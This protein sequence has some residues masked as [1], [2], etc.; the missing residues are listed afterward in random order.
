MNECEHISMGTCKILSKEKSDSFNSGS[1]IVQGGI[2]CGKNLHVKH[3]ILCD[4]IGL[5]ENI[6]S[7]KNENFIK[8]YNNIIP[9]DS[10]ISI[11][12]SNK[13]WNSIFSRNL[14]F[15]NSLVGN[16]VNIQNL[17]VD[18]NC[19]L[20]SNSVLLKKGIHECLVNI[21]SR[22][23][24]V[25][26]KSPEVSFQ[27]YENKENILNINSNNIEINSILNIKNND[28]IIMTFN[29]IERRAL[30]N[31][32]LFVA[33]SII[34]SFK[35]ITLKNSCQLDLDS[36]INLFKLESNDNIKI[37]LSTDDVTIGVTRKIIIYN[38]INEIYVNIENMVDLKDKYSGA[39]FLFD[40]KRWILI[41]KF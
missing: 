8:F 26:F 12:N 9:D 10:S 14:V 2:G 24:Q 21:D 30:I 19:L 18:N 38:N 22:N 27:N 13:S 29:P 33:S 16:N 32:E 41:G 34:K 5:N 3:S 25:I 40:G 15:K 28:N 35:K 11:G 1:L 6:I 17:N 39:E 20:G 36:E 31:G 7:F 37:N 4:D 23:S